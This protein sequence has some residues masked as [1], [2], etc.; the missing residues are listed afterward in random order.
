MKRIMICA[1]AL[2]LGSAGCAEKDP[3]QTGQPEA[4]RSSSPAPSAEKQQTKPLAELP[5]AAA[6]QPPKTVEKEQ[7]VK[8]ELAETPKPT[9]AKQ[10]KPKPED[11][12]AEEIRAHIQA[13]GS[14][15]KAARK[16]ATN[17][18]AEIG[19]SRPKRHLSE[20]SG[21]VK[22]TARAISQTRQ[23][24]T[25][26]PVK[27]EAR[28]AA[29]GGAKPAG[30]PPHELNLSPFYKK[31]IDAKGLPIVSSEKVPDV[32]L[33]VARMLVLRMLSKRPDIQKAMVKN[34][35]RVAVMAK[36]EVTT[37]IPEHSDLYQVFP[38][39]DWNG[40]CR[41]VG[42]TVERPVSSCAEENLLGYR[43]DPY[44]GESIFIHEF[45]H[46]IYNM[47][48]TAVDKDFAPTLKSAYQNALA[49]GLW[50]NTY[51]ATGMEEYWAEGVQ[52]WFNANL[53][54]T[55]AN[56]IHNQVN[57]RRELKRYD[58]GLAKLIAQIFPD[59]RWR[60]S[61]PKQPIK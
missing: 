40:R 18:L 5:P 29:A 37:D 58:L 15:E 54:S 35:T 4:P 3:P 60:Y 61:Y 24:S 28:S 32:A 26:V 9:A 8:P 17:A 56:G 20:K 34:N 1:A 25:R 42:A 10:A 41:G 39:T 51:S 21:V 19:A 31:Y 38:G 12:L 30:K 49:K 50:E 57:T 7:A 55:P 13:L 16:A 27:P 46:T 36:S 2:L 14:K 11:A 23:A 52:S 53:E 33:E 43:D 44:K 59:E 22:T 47:G 48:I 6:P 45:A